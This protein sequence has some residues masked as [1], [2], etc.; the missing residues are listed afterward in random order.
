MHVPDGDIEFFDEEIS[1][2]QSIKEGLV[3]IPE[4][5]IEK[6]VNMNRAKRKNWMRNKPCLCGSGR[7]FK[8][9]CWSKYAGA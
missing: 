9:C 5:E 8:Q 4:E 6:V 2:D 7:K 3:P 1:R